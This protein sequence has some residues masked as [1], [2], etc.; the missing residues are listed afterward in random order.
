MTYA[1]RD[2]REPAP[3]L[4]RACVE[5][6]LCAT[7]CKWAPRPQALPSTS[8]CGVSAWQRLRRAPQKSRNSGR[9]QCMRRPPISHLLEPAPNS[10]S[11][12]AWS[13]LLTRRARTV[14]GRRR[15]PTVAAGSAAV[16]VG[17]GAKL[18][19]LQLHVLEHHHGPHAGRAGLGKGFGRTEMVASRAACAASE[20]SQHS[21]AWLEGAA[22][23]A[24]ATW[25]AHA[26][27]EVVRAAV[28][29]TMF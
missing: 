16:D 28:R 10:P 6:C 18:H 15:P 21:Q 7:R 12:R 27:R 24:I 23:G 1:L 13:A 19:V 25:R 5:M 9:W 26:R 8:A 3:S 2:G 29:H 17:E 11:R 20:G 22:S 14:S 4:S